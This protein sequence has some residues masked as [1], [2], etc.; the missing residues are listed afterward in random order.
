MC[1]PADFEA[2]HTCIIRLGELSVAGLTTY[3][4]CKTASLCRKLR[5]RQEE[6]EADPLRNV[7]GRLATEDSSRQ[8]WER[9]READQR[10]A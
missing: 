10:P 1:G 4:V 7:P 8:L 9:S 3:S 2:L 6:Q 5:P